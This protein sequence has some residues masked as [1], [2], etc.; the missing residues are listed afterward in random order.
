MSPRARHAAIACALGAALALAGAFALVGLRLYAMFERT[1]RIFAG[2]AGTRP[3][4][5]PD[6]AAVMLAVV[7]AL[8]AFGAIALAVAGRRAALA[9]ERASLIE[10]GA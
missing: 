10:L 1:L 6:L 2:D 3:P 4:T 9:V 8:L 5:G 7:A